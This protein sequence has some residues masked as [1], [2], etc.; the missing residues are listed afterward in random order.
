[1]QTWELEESEER[2]PGG[3][4]AVHSVENPV[5]I[6]PWQRPMHTRTR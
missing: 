4:Q 3:A 6:G 1:M 5:N 2:S